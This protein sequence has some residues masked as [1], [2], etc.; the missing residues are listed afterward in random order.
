MSTASFLPNPNQVLS[1][2]YLSVKLWD[3][4]MGLALHSAST[5]ENIERN[6]SKLHNSGAMDDE[7][8][9]T[10]SGDGKH[11]VTGG[12]DKSANLMDTNA[13]WNCTIPCQHKTRSGAPVGQVLTYNKRRK[14]CPDF[15]LNS[16]NK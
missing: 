13:T 15:S 7:F 6:L 16:S 8:F 3:L 5:T 12:Y 14:L 9:M 10:V 4:R 1:R 11:V 2:D